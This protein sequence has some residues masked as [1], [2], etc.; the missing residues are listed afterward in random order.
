MH[1]IGEG[2]LVGVVEPVGWIRW[3]VEDVPLRGYNMRKGK[4]V[5]PVKFID[6]VGQS[7]G[8]IDARQL[9]DGVGFLSPRIAAIHGMM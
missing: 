2:E 5:F 1:S 7:I 4:E 9:L 6:G 3:S 8:G